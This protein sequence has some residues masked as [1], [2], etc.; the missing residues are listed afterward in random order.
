VKQ[1][2]S[3]WYKLRQWALLSLRDLRNV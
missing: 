3:G 1:R 2:Q